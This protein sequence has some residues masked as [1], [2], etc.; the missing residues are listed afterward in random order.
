MKIDISSNDN[1]GLNYKIA[2]LSYFYQIFKN[3]A[4]KIT[5]YNN[6]VY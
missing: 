4:R 5:T 2:K 3:F 1:I 6:R